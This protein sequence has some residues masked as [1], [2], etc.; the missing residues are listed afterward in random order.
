MVECKSDLPSVGDITIALISSNHFPADEFVA[1]PVRSLVN[2]AR[3][4][5]H[6]CIQPLDRQELGSA[7]FA[8]NLGSVANGGTVLSYLPELPLPPP[9]LPF[10]LPLFPFPPPLLL[11]LPPPFPLPPL[12]PLPL[13]ALPLPPLFPLPLPPPLDDPLFP[14]D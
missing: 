12:L 3:H 2:N 14:D 6:E 8:A 11:L 9:L 5:R 10:P 13:P 7:R 1:H 4:E